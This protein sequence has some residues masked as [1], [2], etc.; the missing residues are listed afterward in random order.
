MGLFSY[1]PFMECNHAIISMKNKI[2]GEIVINDSVINF[3]AGIGY[4]EKD[5]GCSFPKSYIWCQGNNFKNCDASFMLSIA[6]IPFK[7]F[8]FR[9]IICSLMVDSVEYRF[10]TY[11]NSKIIKFSTDD[12]ILDIV[13]KKGDY[14]LCVKCNYGDGLKL[15][16]PVKGVMK[17]DIIESITE[18]IR[19]TLIK[20]KKVIFD[21]VSSNCGLEIVKE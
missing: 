14:Y 12:N 16:A 6:N 1:V 8:N 15:I 7:L 5:Y 19:V 3:N 13:L 9:G 17:K 20:N 21:D 2:N 4:I 18:D 11:N 10:A